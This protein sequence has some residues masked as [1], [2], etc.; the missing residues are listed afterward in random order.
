MSG[1]V[2]LMLSVNPNLTWRDVKYIL[3]KTATQVDFVTTGAIGHP[4][5]AAGVTLPTGYAWEQVWVRNAAG[6]YFQNWYGFGRVNVDAAVA[7]ARNFVSP[8]KAA[9]ESSWANSTTLSSAIPDNTAAGVTSTMAVADNIQIE[10]VQIRVWAT[11]ADISELA[12]ELTSPS[13]TKSII[14]N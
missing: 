12:L 11:H 4:H 7:M 14:V 10:G 13:G 2:A 1:A 6:F 3:A 5:A 8:L 9:F